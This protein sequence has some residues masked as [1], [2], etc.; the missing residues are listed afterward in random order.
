LKRY[1]LLCLRVTIGAIFIAASIDKIIH[2]EAF[3]RII[4]NYQVLPNGLINLTAIL[5]PWIELLMGVLLL[6]GI[7]LPGAALLSTLLFLVFFGTLLFNLARGLNV[8]CGCFSTSQTES[9]QTAWYVI[10][11]GVFLLLGISLCRQVLRRGETQ[12]S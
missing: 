1:L 5:L 4:Y 6:T 8:H 3:A 2:P 9:A 10:R 11:D 12:P 7:W